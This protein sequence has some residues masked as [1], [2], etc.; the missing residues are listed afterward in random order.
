MFLM[1]SIAS[2]ALC[3]ASLLAL[4]AHAQGISIDSAVYHERLEGAARTI[5]PATRLL[6]GDR[7]ITIL[8]WDAPA[9]G[10]YTA[11]SPVPESLEIESTSFRDLEVSADGGRSW[12]R[13]D[14]PRRMPRGTTHFRWPVRGGGQLSYRA[15][16]R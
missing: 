7:V 8:R 5:R 2:A 9:Q 10:R 14:D 4:P 6:R 3:A 11:T 1:R 16:V 15:V 13:L 12:K